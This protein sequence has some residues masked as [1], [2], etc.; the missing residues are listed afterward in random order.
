MER[1]A[2]TGGTSGTQSADCDE[3][4]GKD[5][6]ES[7][8]IDACCKVTR[9]AAAYELENFDEELRRRREHEGATLHELADY[10]NNR[11]T[12]VS[13]EEADVDIDA[14]PATVRTALVEDEV[15][16]IGRRNSIREA[17]VGSVDIEQLTGDFV[18]HETIRRH[19]KDHL[20]ISTARGSIETKTELENALNSSEKQHQ[21]MIVGALRRAGD[22]GIITGTD[23]RV[24]STRV[25]CRHCSTTYRLQELIDNC[26]CDCQNG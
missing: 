8:A 20:D 12:A 9:V 6:T 16:P 17:V 14:E 22:R 5:G 2:S 25:E 21:E 7:E 4:A 10:L 26:G 3:S 23:F 11:L 15:L 18:S 19:L 24:F 1:K 13:L